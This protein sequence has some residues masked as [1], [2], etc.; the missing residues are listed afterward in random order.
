MKKK[1]IYKE[2]VVACCKEV[3]SHFLIQSE[4]Y[5]EGE[6]ELRTGNLGLNGCSLKIVSAVRIGT[7]RSWFMMDA[8]RRRGGKFA[9]FKCSGLLV[10]SALAFS[11]KS[12]VHKAGPLPPSL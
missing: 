3:R 1:R 10:C 6:G 7:D 11:D 9:S 2:T 12:S 4:E 5:D 8:Y